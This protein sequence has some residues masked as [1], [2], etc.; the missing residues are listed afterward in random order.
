[1]S[2]YTTCLH[3]GDELD[4]V[5]RLDYMIYRSRRRGLSPD[6]RTRCAGVTA[7]GHTH[8]PRPRQPRTLAEIR[9]SFPRVRRTQ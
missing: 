5:P 8:Q 2:D 1:M 3:C 9:A 4:V 6:E 7:I